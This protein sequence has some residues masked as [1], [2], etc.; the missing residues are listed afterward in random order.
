MPL[1][2]HLGVAPSF[3]ASRI[4]RHR[5]HRRP[6]H[7]RKLDPVPAHRD[8]PHLPIPLVSTLTLPF[9]PPVL[10]PFLP[11]SPFP[12]CSPPLRT[13]SH[14]AHTAPAAH[15]LR[16]VRVRRVPVLSSPPSSTHL[17][18][19]SALTHPALPS[20]PAAPARAPR[21]LPVTGLRTRTQ[22]GIARTHTRLVYARLGIPFLPYRPSPPLLVS[23]IHPF[24]FPESIPHRMSLPTAP[25]LRS[26]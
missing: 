24:P 25:N 17:S 15:T 9:L 5:V 20:F 22:L 6:S 10:P 2:L 1:T 8:R 4:P 16:Y 3:P 19:V 18:L 13:P 26:R 21:S 7:T 23:P 11:P 12:R 14:R